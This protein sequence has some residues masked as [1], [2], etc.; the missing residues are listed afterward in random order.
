MTE[1][2]KKIIDEIVEKKVN[3]VLAGIP[4][5]NGHNGPY[6]DYEMPIRNISHWICIFEKYFDIKKDDRYKEAVKLLSRIY[7]DPEILPENTCCVCRV[8]CGKDKTNG[9]IGPAWVIEGLLASARVLKDDTFYYKAVALFFTQ[10]FS[11]KY[12]LWSVIEID[13]RNFGFDITFNHQLWFAAAGSQI[14]DY[15]YNDVID[16]QIKTFLDKAC[17]FFVIH[18]TGLIFHYVKY[19]PNFRQAR[20]YN[21]TFNTTQAGLNHEKPSLIYKE[22]GYHS[23]SIYA[24]ALL[25]D[26]YKEERFFKSEKVKKAIMFAF[27]EHELERLYNS[28]SKLDSTKIAKNSIERLNAYAYPYNSPAFEFM[29]IDKVFGDGKHTDLFE[30]MMDIQID[31]TYDS[32]KKSFSRNTEDS[33]TLDARLYELIRAF[34]YKGR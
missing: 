26:R 2:Q 27:D 18:N 31:F 3:D 8:K 33:E 24:F 25:Y 29:L 12:G 1:R 4:I 32:E 6:Y 34:N 22:E 14:I 5:K 21:K 13:G 7:L 20:W 9:V 30:K 19:K 16:K 10:K 11:E 17:N 23:F 15:K 28:C